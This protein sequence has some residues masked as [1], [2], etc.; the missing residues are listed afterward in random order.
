MKDEYSPLVGGMTL[1]SSV[2]YCCWCCIGLPITA[3]VAFAIYRIYELR[4]QPRFVYFVGM[5]LGNMLTFVGLLDQV[6]HFVYP[7]R[8]DQQQRP[9]LLCKLQGAIDGLDRVIF[10]VNYF[11]ALMDRYLLS[12]T[13]NPHRQGQQQQHSS[14]LILPLS[15]QMAITVLFCAIAKLSNVAT[16]TDA[17]SSPPF[18]HHES[19]QDEVMSTAI[20]VALLIISCIVVK[21]L[22]FIQTHQTS[23]DAHHPNSYANKKKK[24]KKGKAVLYNFILPLLFV[25]IFHL[26]LTVYDFYQLLINTRSKPPGDQKN[27]PTRSLV[28]HQGDNNNRLYL[29]ELAAFFS[30]GHPFTFFWLC[31]HFWTIWN[32]R[33]AFA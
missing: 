13:V 12:I 8:E 10:F 25:F 2:R 15:W 17:S 26:P 1:F 5:T 18:S 14:K 22:I 6:A 27:R 33:V 16:P 9:H 19:H 3:F 7:P 29:T 24:K 30:M 28:A 31:P 32:N 23:H 21:V 20:V 4:N 11:M